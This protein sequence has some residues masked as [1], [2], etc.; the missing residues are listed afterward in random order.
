MLST[1][2]T[3]E[4][5]YAR[6]HHSGADVC[7]VD[8]EDS[9]PPARKE[10]ARRKAVAFFTMADPSTRCSVRINSVTEA[11]GLRDLLALRE[12][13]VTPTIVVVPKVESARDLEIVEAVLGGECP[14]LELLAVVET[15][16]GLERLRDITT[17]SGR[18]RGIIFGSADYAAA[19]GIELAWEPLVYARSL[20]ANAARAAN[21]EAIDSPLFDLTDLALLRREAECARA[22]GY[23]GKIALHPDQVPVINEVF[24]PKPAELQHAHRVVAAAHRSGQGITTVSGSMVGRPFF[25]A[26]RRLLD[27]FEPLVAADSST[28]RASDTE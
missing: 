4:D 17:F 22:L 11:A 7:Q 20:L 5:K 1:P 3:A 19:L 27:E 15:P 6:C 10:E 13:S 9:I 25:E 23:S 21:I 12:Y 8:L 24:S 16:R 28:S 14:G 2:A 18:L 26:S